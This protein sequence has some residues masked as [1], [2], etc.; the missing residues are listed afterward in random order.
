[1]RARQRRAK[2]NTRAK[3]PQPARGA[4][5]DEIG[6]NIAAVQAF[7]TH[8][9]RD[10]SLSQRLAERI[11]NAVGHP[12]FLVAIALFVAIW[13]GFSVVRQLLGLVAW[14]PAPYFWLQGLVSLCALLITTVV[15]IK[16][17]RVARLEEQR[18]HLDL[19]I[20]LLIEQKAAKMIDLLEELRR[21]APGIPDRHDPRAAALQQAMNP[22]RVLAA[23]GEVA[24]STAVA[25]AVPDAAAAPLDPD[26]GSRSEDRSLK[27]PLPDRGGAGTGT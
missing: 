24:P 10:L 21:D 9:S 27:R 16:Q 8:Q 25:P 23:L 1:V 14:D 4:E 17:N 19:K 13:I 26:A 20:T 12:I 3:A 22:D 2:V 7:Y 5:A 15:L 18:A 6:Q 11:A